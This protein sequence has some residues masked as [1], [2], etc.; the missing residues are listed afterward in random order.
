MKTINIIFTLLLFSLSAEA[1]SLKSGLTKTVYAINK[2]LH[3]DKNVRFTNQ[4][5]ALFY[6]TKINANLQGE[7]ICIDSSTRLSQKSSGIIFNVMKVKSFAIKAGEIVAFGH[8]HET[9]VAIQAG[10][11]QEMQALKK[12]LDALRF[13]CNQYSEQDPKFKCD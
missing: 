3:Q 2:I 5:Y 8:H 12:E 6:P 7:F 4:N 10:N 13:I 9:I 1:Q 11:E